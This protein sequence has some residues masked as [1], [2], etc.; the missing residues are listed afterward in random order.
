M[1]SRQQE[2]SDSGTNGLPEG[3]T[4][5]GLSVIA[6]ATTSVQSPDGRSPGA[7]GSLALDYADWLGQIGQ[8]PS[9]LVSLDAAV[10]A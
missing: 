9:S 6:N 2:P 8:C 3:N 10:A 7:P 4:M 5:R 1:R